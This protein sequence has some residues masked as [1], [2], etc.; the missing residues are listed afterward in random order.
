MQPKICWRFGFAA[1]LTLAAAACSTQRHDGTTVSATVEIAISTTPEGARCV[2]ERRGQQI[3]VIAK[4]PQTVSFDRSARDITLS[5]E[6]DRH[7]P[8]VEV[9]SSRYVGGPLKPAPSPL[10]GLIAAAVVAG[11]PANYDYPS[12]YHFKPVPFKAA[13]ERLR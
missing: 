11:S 3:A 1:V 7:I 5:C 8:T 12:Q 10:A 13:V 4:T 6:L 2:L 9:V